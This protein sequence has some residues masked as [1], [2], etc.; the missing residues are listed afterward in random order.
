MMD[1]YAKLEVEILHKV[2]NDRQQT[3]RKGRKQNKLS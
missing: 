1:K 2:L 3:V